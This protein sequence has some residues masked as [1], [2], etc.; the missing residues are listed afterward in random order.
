MTEALRKRLLS[1]DRLKPYVWKLRL[2]EDEYRQLREFVVNTPEVIDREYAIIAI[3]YIAE[4]YKREYDGN[5]TNPLGYIS[6]ESLW[7]ASGLDA[8]TYVYRT[9]KTNRYLESIFMLGG[10]PMYYILQRKDIKLLKALCRIYKGDSSSLDNSVGAGQAVAF[11][12]SI[13]QYASLYQFLKT[14]LLQDAREVYAEDDLANKSSLANQF[15]EA[16]K[17]AYDE[18][19]RDKFRIEW[20]ID[21]DP[22]S[23]YMRRMI[24]L[25]LRPEEFGGL[26]QYLRFERAGSWGFPALMQ[27]RVLRVSLQFMK[28]NEVVGNDDTRRT[29]ITFE[30]SGQ[31]DTGFEAAGSVPWAIL[32]TI[33]TDPFDRITVIV[34]DDSGKPYEVQHF[35]C[36]KEYLQLWAMQNEVN[37]WSST[38]NNQA[39]TAVVYSGYYELSGEE[40]I[41]KPFYDKTNGITGPWNFAFIADHVTLKHGSDSPISLWNRDGYIQFA[42]TLYT[43]VLRYKAGKVR[44]MYNEDPEIYPEPE[45]EEWYPAIFQRSDIKAYHF[46]TRDMINTQP[47]VVD[48]QKIE[49]KPFDASNNDEYQE[50]TKENT[51][52]YG[53]LK[54]CLTIKDDK[55]IYPILYLPSLLEHGNALPVVRDFENSQLQYVDNTNHIVKAHV[56]IPMDKMP[57]EIST[58]LRVWGNDSE[59]VELDA[60]LPTLIKEVYLD[61]QIT[62]YLQDGEQ[63]ILPYLLRNRI[64][65]HDYSRDGYS[66]YECFNVGVLNEKGSIQ[67]WK[68]GIKLTTQNVPGFDSKLHLSGIWY[69]C[70][71]WQHKETNVLGIQYR[72]TTEGG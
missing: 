3:I 8:E 35:D 63:F 36:K 62:K 54:L 42:P 14:L 1:I 43:S 66:E 53:R 16:V 47:D 52:D 49:F 37:R 26:N 48:I 25:W 56:D 22:S 10:L 44:Y 70:E 58:P 31:D 27:Q 40:H 15:I 41:S 13:R 21:Y 23:P 68:R 34:T 51:P 60:I 18:I 65:I 6:A 20:I 19:M 24:R 64:S 9:A 11:Q 57:L 32:R 17:S 55:K 30:N 46:A 50:W 33:P 67:K 7:K 5:V 69:A 29:L 4:W 2:T 59:F 61:G 28:G 71:L 38:R 39:E 12:E 72:D 45:T